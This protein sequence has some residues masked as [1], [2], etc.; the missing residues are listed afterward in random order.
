VQPGRVTHADFQLALAAVQEDV[1]VNGDTGSDNGRGVG[2]TVLDTK[3]VQQLADDPDDFLSQLQALAAAGGG[4][5][6]SALVVVDGF[7]NGS[8]MPPKSA[9]ASIRINPDLFSANM[10]LLPGV[11]VVSKLRPKRAQN[12]AMEL[13]STQTRGPVVC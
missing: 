12:P 5:P 9:I 11:G 4:P 13:C 8:V 1:Q 6:E 2:T 7:Q 3:Q 10:S